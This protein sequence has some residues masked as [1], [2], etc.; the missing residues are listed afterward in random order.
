M[1]SCI[2]FVGPTVCL[3]KMSLNKQGENKQIITSCWDKYQKENKIA[4]QRWARA[5]D[6]RRR[7]KNYEEMC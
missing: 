5:R 7:G 4:G 3:R 2:A 1:L 6:C